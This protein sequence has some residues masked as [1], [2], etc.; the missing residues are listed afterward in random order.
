MKAIVG[1]LA[2]LLTVW[3]DFMGA[4]GLYATSRKSGYEAVIYFVV[5]AFSLLLG[6]YQTYI[7]GSAVGKEVWK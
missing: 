7:V 1:L 3:L 5:G 6:L 4:Y 2:I